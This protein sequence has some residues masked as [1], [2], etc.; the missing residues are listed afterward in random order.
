MAWSG[1]FPVEFH[2]AMASGAQAPA[3]L[4]PAVRYETQAPFM[5]RHW[6]ASETNRLNQAHWQRAQ[7]REINEWLREQLTI[8]RT[9][10]LYETRQNA[11]LSGITKTLSEDVVGPD[12]PQLEVQSDNDAYNEALERVWRE[13]FSAPTFRPDLSGAALLKL[14]VRNLPRCGEFLARIATDELAAGPVQ[15]RLLP[16]PPRRLESPSGSGPRNCLGV[17]FDAYDRPIRYWIK[18]YSGDGYSYQHVPVPPDLILHGFMLDEEG[19]ARG[20]PWFTPALDPAADLR[21]YDVQVQDAARQAAD[22]S[23]ML[24]TDREDAPLWT[25]PES[26]TVERRTWKMAPPGWKPFVYPAT[27][28]P[29]QYPDFRAER[30]R[31]TGLP[32]GMPLLMIRL[33]SSKHNYSSARLDTQTY[34]LAIASLQA[35]LSGTEQST[36]FLNRLVQVIEVEAR[37]SIPA[38]RRKPPKVTNVWTWKPRPHVDPAKEADA[39]TISLENRSDSLIGVLAARGVSLDSHIKSLQRV[40]KAFAAAKVTRPA[41]MADSEAESPESKVQSP[42]SKAGKGK[43]S[44]KAARGE[45]AAA[46]EIEDALEAVNARVSA[47]DESATSRAKPTPQPIPSE[48]GAQ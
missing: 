37:M 33:D 43:K 18:E 41:W 32:M 2:G 24:Y 44:G 3:S 26:T 13:W 9:R 19:Q 29:V 46:R 38:L 36:G 48:A 40:E 15:M 45:R 16:I 31:E 7:D 21:D 10:S 6:E 28:P 22:Q 11:V 8:L 17:E 39:E 34:N 14:W 5:Q 23:G 35:W 30:Q 42:K 20:F 25:A 12:G 4:A 1:E 47:S 27:N